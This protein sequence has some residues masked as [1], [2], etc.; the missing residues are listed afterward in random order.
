MHHNIDSTAYN[1]N[2]TKNKKKPHTTNKYVN[3]S[4]QRR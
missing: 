4:A 1:I 2:I 3:K